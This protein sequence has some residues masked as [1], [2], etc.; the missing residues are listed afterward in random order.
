MT[1][2][3]RS[4]AIVA[5]S[6]V[7]GA[8]VGAQIPARRRT[9][10]PARSAAPWSV[11]F[12]DAVMRRNPTV[13]E[14]WDYTAGLV[15]TAIARVGERTHDPRYAA[16]VKENM[17]RFVQPDGTIRTYQQ[18]EYNLDQ[19]NQGRLLFALYDGTHD[20]RYQRAADLLRQQLR[21]QPRTSE[22]GFWH[23]KIYPQQMWLDGLYMA[24]PFYAQ[25]A[26]RANDAAGLNDVAR[27]F[28]L[29]ARHARDPK[30]GLFYHA[31]DAAHT[32]FWADAATGLSR[33]FWGRA[34]GW[35][36]M[37]AMDVLDYLPANH[38]DRGALIA[39]V[40]DLADAVAKVQ[41]PASGLW[42]QV[43]DQ[44]N[45]TGNYH[46]ASASSMFVYALAK[47]ARKGY[48]EP[49]FADVARR[50]FD[51]IVRELVKTGSDGLPSLT[52]ICK[53]AGLGPA[54]DRRRDGSFAYYVSEPVVAD[55][56]KGVGAFI[57]AALEVGQ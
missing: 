27:Q 35:Y 50:G 9:L 45:R 43:L 54:S 14:K 3:R 47:G 25:F 31:W 20:A 36:L 39:T 34:D 46:E 41:D 6:L 8:T 12:A 4:L 1:L 44:P 42:Y 49:R 17:D 5:A 21:T 15:L 24:E 38:P 57:L 56:Y 37:A 18:D 33:N 23:K 40:R 13:S 19:I 16:Y 10:P 2:G 26:L 55:D 53:V 11:R 22:G 30:T 52:G 48:L 7:A 28:L 51:G 29:V 32:Q